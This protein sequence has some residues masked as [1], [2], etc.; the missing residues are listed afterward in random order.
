MFHNR[1][2][3]QY[4]IGK[5][6]ARVITKQYAYYSFIKQ[7]RIAG[8]CKNLSHNRQKFVQHHCRGA[9]NSVV[10]NIKI[11]SIFKHEAIV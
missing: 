2:F 10:M 6:D 8:I 9:P 4:R 7:V 5:R 3:L 11:R 1:L